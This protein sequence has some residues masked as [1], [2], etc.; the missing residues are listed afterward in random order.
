MPS[1]GYYQLDDIELSSFEVHQ[2]ENAYHQGNFWGSKS[3]GTIYIA[4][5]SFALLA[6]CSFGLY[7]VHQH[8]HF[9]DIESI[10]SLGSK[11][12]ILTPE[13]LAAAAKEAEIRR[14]AGLPHSYLPAANYEDP[15]DA[16]RVDC[17]TDTSFPVLGGLD[18]VRFRLTGDLIFGNP[19]YTV[20]VS[21]I[22]R[23]YTFWFSDKSMIP[24]FEADREAYFPKW[25]G[26]DVNNFCTVGG[27]L[28]ALAAY[29]VDL[30]EPQEVDRHIAFGRGP[31][32]NTVEC[33]N[34]YNSIYGLPVNGVFN[35]RCVSMSNFQKPVSGLLPQM[36]LV[37]IPV[38]MSELYGV[39]PRFPL[40]HQSD[41]LMKDNQDAF[42]LSGTVTIDELEFG[43]ANQ[44]KSFDPK[45]PSPPTN[46]QETPPVI[47]FANI[48]T[49]IGF[50]SA[51]DSLLESSDEFVTKSKDTV[52]SPMELTV[53]DSE[54]QE[55]SSRGIDESSEIVQGNEIIEDVIPMEKALEQN[56]QL[57]SKVEQVVTEQIALTIG[58][59]ENWHGPEK[60]LGEKALLK[61][62]VVTAGELSPGLKKQISQGEDMLNETSNEPN[63]ST[64][65]K[66]EEIVFEHV[67][68]EMVEELLGEKAV[69]DFNP[70]NWHTSQK[71]LGEKA[72][73][74]KGSETLDELSPG[75]LKQISEGED[76]LDADTRH[77]Q[78]LENEIPS[79]EQVEKVSTVHTN[80]QIPSSV[81]PATVVQNQLLEEVEQL[82][83]VPQIDVSPQKEH[84]SEK[85]LGEK[86]LLK[87][88]AET[89]DELSPGLLKQI[90][91]A[92][93]QLNK[94]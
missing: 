67:Q 25:G 40:T 16:V 66:Y 10:T 76:V 45:M 51:A 26:F 65:D 19:K 24:L 34:A 47:A 84:T 50:S 68:A 53:G 92:E 90:A 32:E 58:N 52:I 46:I 33:D 54:H 63:A 75:L 70:Q 93:S 74:K 4:G 5:A 69:E 62:G 80:I 29:T 17:C 11:F 20:Q 78:T 23:T 89:V 8:K 72:L 21:G 79:S 43:E 31:T 38:K 13:Q 12:K 81:L 22:T 56:E 28:E 1:Q 64:V 57:T 18:V 87:R 91:Q 14:I 86:A 42:G 41:I 37:A 2:Y 71:P 49:P 27:S 85:P 44:F 3:R 48:F 55:M 6:F 36:P 94:K 39:S 73:L 61:R 15:C 88:G 7:Q 30:S 35:T 60:P 77:Q 9:I 83:T 59:P 82:P